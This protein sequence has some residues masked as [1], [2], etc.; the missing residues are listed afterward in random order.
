MFLLSPRFLAL[1]LIALTVI[2][3]LPSQPDASNGQ[4]A[5]PRMTVVKA[6]TCAAPNAAPSCVIAASNNSV[7]R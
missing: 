6:V 3:M 1:Q 2:V 4:S 5:A 7:V